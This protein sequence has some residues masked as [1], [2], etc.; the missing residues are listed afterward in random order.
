MGGLVPPKVQGVRV[1]K[2]TIDM[3]GEEVPSL[4]RDAHVV[5]SILDIQR[6][7]TADRPVKQVAQVPQIV[8][9]YRKLRTMLVQRAEVRN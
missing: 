2:A 5:I 9:D 1:V 3:E 4:G 6:E 7:H 8:Q